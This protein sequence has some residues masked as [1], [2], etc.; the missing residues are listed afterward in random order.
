MI[1]YKHSFLLVALSVVDPTA[2][3]ASRV[4]DSCQPSSVLVHVDYVIIKTES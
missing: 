1:S 4:D 3:A 2:D